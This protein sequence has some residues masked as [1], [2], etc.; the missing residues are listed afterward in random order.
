VAVDLPFELKAV[1][2]MGAP[3]SRK[4]IHFGATPGKHGIFILLQNRRGCD[5]FGEM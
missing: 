1:Y 2:A 5:S 3:K 4:S